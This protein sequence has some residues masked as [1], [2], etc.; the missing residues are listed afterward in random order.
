MLVGVD[1]VA[2]SGVS[3]GVSRYLRE[4]LNGVMGL[5]LDDEFVLYSPGLV[6]VPPLQGRWRVRVP[7]RRRLHFP[8]HWLRDTLPRMVAEDGVEV[9]WGQNTTL[10][11]RL[12]RPC[13][14]VLTVHDLTGIVCPGTMRLRPRISWGLNFRA[15]VRAADAILV[16]S[17]A[18]GRL[19]CRFKL[20]AP[21]TIRVVYP[22]NSGSI[23][24]LS[25]GTARR[26][27]SERF[28]LDGD[29]MLTVGTLEPRKNYPTLLRALRAIR[30]APPL[31][32]VGAPGWNHRRILDAI[33]EA[34]ADGFVKYLGRAGDEELSALY[35]AAKLSIYASFYEGFGLP[36]LESMVC[37]CPALCS[38]SSSMPEVG[39]R[40]AE[41][42]RPRDAQ[43]LARRL[44]ALLSDGNRLAEMRAAG[45]VQSAR[46]GFERTASQ[47]LSVLRS[48]QRAT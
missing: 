43:D 26:V 25:A 29:F 5:S 27:V 36:V 3:A 46:F 6:S 17:A 34:E 9:F 20:V 11:L 21:E 33:R 47:V 32:I 1:A 45:L 12:E 8:G 2:F 28:S 40:A 14:R 30:N 19:L 41:Y 37:G 18:T 15:V 10:P 16:D 24:R 7:D 48:R 42:F 23:A 38:W 13:R 39:G 4:V 31:V 22:G 44:S 35:S